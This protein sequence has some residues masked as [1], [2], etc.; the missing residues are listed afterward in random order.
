MTGVFLFNVRFS[1]LTF[2]LLE[3]TGLVYVS[4]P[5]V[6]LFLLHAMCISIVTRCGRINCI[7]ALG[8]KVYNN[9]PLSFSSALTFGQLLN[10]NQ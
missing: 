8:F 7:A 9:Q 2:G 5:E 10:I 1:R 3:D 4:F 6:V